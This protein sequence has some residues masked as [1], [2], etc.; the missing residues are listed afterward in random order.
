MRPHQW[1]KNLICFAGLLFSENELTS[2]YITSNFKIFISFCLISSAVYIINDIVDR[3]K[4][5]LHPTKKNRPIACGNTSILTSLILIIIIVYASIF[6]TRSVETKSF[7]CLLI[8]F[9]TNIIY[10]VALKNIFL[11][12]VLTI[13]FG[14]L[15]RLTAGIFS[16]ND[17][18][19]VWIILCTFFLTIYIGFS[20][21]FSELFEYKNNSFLQRPVLGSYTES[22][23]LDYL[24]LTSTLTIVSYTMFTLI[25]NKN[26]TLVI[27]VPIV[28]Y[29]IM[30]YNKILLNSNMCEEPEKL[31]YK[32][33]PL[34]LCV[35]CWLITFMIIYNYKLEIF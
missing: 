12:D 18:P 10:S 4:D 23:L 11:I 24:R 22:L 13:G 8:Y 29:G 26:Q 32:C 1:H 7:A 21:R 16:I 3:K 19:T 6:F 2:I 14:F 33:F 17:T 20:K 35:L 27:T 9:F 5:A 28:L 25:S 34:F 30:Y 31:I 15:L